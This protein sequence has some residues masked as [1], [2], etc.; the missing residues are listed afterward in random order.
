MSGTKRNLISIPIEHPNVRNAEAFLNSWSEPFD[1]QKSEENHFT[2]RSSASET[3][4]TVIF[5]E[6]YRKATAYD[7]RHFHPRS[8]SACSTMNGT[9]LYVILGNDP[10]L[11]NSLASHF[12]GR[13]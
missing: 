13:E 3:E 4:V 1:L 10:D 12:A 6:D 2:F 8:S 7:K 11:V 9:A 5:F